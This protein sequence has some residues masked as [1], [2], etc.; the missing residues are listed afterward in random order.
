[1]ALTCTYKIEVVDYSARTD[2]TSICAGFSVDAT[3]PMGSVSNSSASVTLH[4]NNG[5]L[6]PNGGGTYSSTDWFNKLLIISAICT[7]NYYN[8]ATDLDSVLFAGII[9]N[10]NLQDNGIQSLVNIEAVDALTKLAT[11]GSVSFPALGLVLETV[12]ALNQDISLLTGWDEDKQPFPLMGGLSSAFDIQNLGNLSDAF[13][14]RIQT[15]PPPP[16]NDIEYASITDLLSDGIVNTCNSVLFPAGVYFSGTEINYQVGYLSGHKTRR[17]SRRYTNSFVDSSPLVGGQL[18]FYD[19]VMGYELEKVINNAKAQGV[20]VGAEVEQ[21][22]SNASQALYGM[23]SVNMG[24]I[25]AVKKNYNA[26]NTASTENDAQGEEDGAKSRTREL[27]NRGSTNSFSPQSISFTLNQIKSKGRES[28][29]LVPGAIFY[30]DKIMDC[31]NRPWQRVDITWTGKGAVSQSS[32]SMLVGISISSSPTETQVVL[33]LDPYFKN[34]S[35]ILGV[36]RLSESK[37][38]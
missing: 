12:F 32:S 15:P 13:L 10:F 11:S 5:A 30:W 21:T 22:N 17:A 8:G 7:D 36:S 18:P 37:A 23:R 19:L 2:F 16:A 26:G 34:S 3:Y 6:T 20:Y 27:V 29:A 28:T 1:M 31:L 33:E 14:D 24:S 4:N 25:F 38:A 9:T 35:F